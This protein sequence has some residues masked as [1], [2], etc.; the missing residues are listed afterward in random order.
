M[1]KAAWMLALL[2]FAVA[3]RA[4]AAPPPLVHDAVTDGVITGAGAILWIGSETL[5]K[6]ALA[7]AACRWCDRN[8][9]GSDALDGFDRSVRETLRMANTS[10]ADLL[11]NVGLGLGT[12]VALGGT[13]LAAGHDGARGNIG[14]DVLVISEALVLAQDLN[15]AV[16]FSAGRERPFVHVLSPAEKGLTAKPTDNNLSFFSGHTTYAFTLATAAGTVCSLHGYSF[17]PYV[18]AGG[19][20]VATATAVLRIGADKHYATDVLTGALVGTAFGIGVPRLFH[21]PQSTSP[22]RA[23][24]GLQLQPG[25]AALSLSGQF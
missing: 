4:R 14:S 20:T 11:S 3:G 15:Q 5:F 2:H 22:S 16:K 24:L 13:A 1:R 8:P 21:P 23:G 10:R 6:H 17:A 18:W 12:A 9:D 7:P 19:L 25:G